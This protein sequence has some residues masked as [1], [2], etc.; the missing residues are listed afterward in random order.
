MSDFN[1]GESDL[2]TAVEEIGSEETVENNQV[3]ETVEESR[4][5][6]IDSREAVETETL[7]GIKNELWHA[8]EESRKLREYNEFLKEAGNQPKV[9]EAEE[10]ELSDDDVPYVGDTKKLIKRE[11]G[12]AREEEQES[13]LV[14][15]MDTIGK[16]RAEADPAFNKNMD[17]AFEL[18]NRENLSG[19]SVLKDLVL[20]KKTAEARV[21]VLEYI[22]SEHPLHV[23][24]D[25]VNK[26][27]ELVERVKANVAIPTQLSSVGGSGKTSKAWTDMS[28]ED[29]ATAFLEV[30]KKM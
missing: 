1:T 6:E 24:S 19:K 20:S 2:G 30:T 15:Q 5:E 17:L 13:R 7:K 11:L 22:A 8:R 10:D 4:T 25:T 23:K 21:K 14:S 3:D 12:R 28:D 16:E 27:K 29:Y 9:K 26:S 18:I